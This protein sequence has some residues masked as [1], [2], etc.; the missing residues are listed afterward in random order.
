[1]LGLIY[2]LAALTPLLVAT[3]RFVL[4]LLPLVSDRV[5]HRAVRLARAKNTSQKS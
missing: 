4:R 1:M 2:G 3:Y 5:H